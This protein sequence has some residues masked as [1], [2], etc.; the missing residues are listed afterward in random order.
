M[1]K[2]SFVC[3]KIFEFPYFRLGLSMK[4]MLLKRSNYIY[5]IFTG[6]FV[7][8]YMQSRTTVQSSISCLHPPTLPVFR[9]SQ[10]RELKINC[11]IGDWSI[12][13]WNYYEKK[14]T[15]HFR[16]SKVNTQLLK[17]CMQEGNCIFSAWILFEELK[18]ISFCIQIKSVKSEIILK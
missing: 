14:W 17:A 8:W 18:Y 5:R 15:V 9:D 12:L 1:G 3:S 10:F 11:P 16:S 13:K 7:L 2:Q 4:K 6:S